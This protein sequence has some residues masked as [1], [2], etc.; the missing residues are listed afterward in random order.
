MLP[1]L[2]EYYV[3]TCVCIIHQDGTYDFFDAVGVS[4]IQNLFKL[5]SCEDIDIDLFYI[6]T[7]APSLNI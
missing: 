3:G 5:Q 7:L 6:S 2:S 4:D 1:T